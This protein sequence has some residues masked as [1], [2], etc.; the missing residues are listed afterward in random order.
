MGWPGM[1][2]YADEVEGGRASGPERASIHGED[3]SCEVY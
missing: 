3:F 1:S 2:G